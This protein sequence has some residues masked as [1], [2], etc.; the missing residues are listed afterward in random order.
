MSVDSRQVGAM[1]YSLILGRV[2][3]CVSFYEVLLYS[4]AVSFMDDPNNSVDR[5][6]LLNI[7]VH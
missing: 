3:Y 7:L 5:F 1:P 2:R 4:I 6:G